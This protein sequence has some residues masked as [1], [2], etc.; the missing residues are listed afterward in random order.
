MYSNS[1]EPGKQPHARTSAAVGRIPQAPCHSVRE[2]PA[3]RG[4]PLVG[5]VVVLHA[6]LHVLQ[7]VQHREHVD[8][9]AQGDEVGFRHEVL[10]PLRVAQAPHLPTEALDGVSLSR[11]GGRKALSVLG[12]L[13]AQYLESRDSL[14]K[15]PPS[16]T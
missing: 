4:P 9:L 3:P 5:R 12:Q 7:L 15:D 13:H 6:A 10:P 8:E 2:R 1:P 11:E 16:E 14:M